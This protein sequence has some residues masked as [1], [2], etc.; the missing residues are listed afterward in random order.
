[1]T[2]QQTA[3]S[4]AHGNQSAT[5]AI[6]GPLTARDVTVLAAVVVMFV[7]SLLPL[8]IIRG[9]VGNLWNTSPLFFLGIGIILPIVVATLFVVRRL[10]PSTRLRVGSLSVDQFASVVAVLATLFFFLTTV[11]SYA[12]PFLIGL[13]G[14]LALLAATVLAPLLP[15]FAGE[16]ANR[17]ASAAHPVARDA[18]P[19]TARPKPRPVL[20]LPATPVNEH[21]FSVNSA[22]DARETPAAGVAA[23]VAAGSP[24]SA[25]VQE[26]APAVVQ[27]AAPAVQEAAP[28]TE[29]AAASSAAPDVVAAG[30]PVEAAADAPA[31]A[32]VVPGE[33]AATEAPA[34]MLNPQVAEQA[35]PEPVAPEP[36]APEPV[37]QEQAAESI[38]ATVNP[39]GRDTE[40]VP[41]WFAVDRVKNVL[42]QATREP[43][44]RLVPGNWILALADRGSEFVVQNAD[45]RVGVLTDLDGIE[46][47][48]EA[49]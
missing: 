38:G 33:A 49:G 30:T 11:T 12:L 15:G 47:A 21:T 20:A 23:A 2:Q 35:A 14:S 3:A 26:A 17:P 46:R 40:A 24:T 42:D 45:G 27:E 1:M 43:V 18:Q 8:A 44:F 5:P 10:S 39:A 4:A 7:S 29:V 37:A 34:T 28:A 9:I 6:L 32:A 41:F 48:P 25:A 31:S 22:G 13:I 16:F 36:V 19:A